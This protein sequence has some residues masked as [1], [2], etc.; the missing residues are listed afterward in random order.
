MIVIAILGLLFPG[1]LLGRALRSPVPWAI[2]FPLSAL[3]LAEIVIAY[4]LLGI[5]IRFGYVLGADLVVTGICLGVWLW[6]KPPAASNS[7]SADQA[8]PSR[9]FVILSAVLVGVVLLGILVR[10]MMFPLSGP[11]VIFRWD[12]LPRLMLQ[13]QSLSYYPPISA[14]DF[15][16]Y[17]Y[18]DGFPP[19]VATVYWWLYAAWGNAAPR[20]TSLA[21]FLQ[22]ATCFALVFYAARTLFGTPGGVLSL[23]VLASSAIFLRGVAIG[24]ENGYTAISYA[25]QLLFAFAAT[26]K[27]TANLV[28]IAGLFAGLGALTREYGPLLSLCGLAVLACRRETLRLAPLFCVVAIACGSPWFIRN[29]VLCRNPLYSMDAGLGFPVNPVLSGFMTEYRKVLGVGNYTLTGWLLVAKALLMGAPL[30]LLV[31]VPGIVAARKYGIALGISTLVAFL[32]WLAAVPKIA[33]GINHTWRVL[34]P[35]CVAFSISAGAFGYVLLRTAKR[36]NALVHVSLVLAIVICGGYAALRCWAE[37]F[38]LSEF[39]DAVVSTRKEPLDSLD[40]VLTLATKLEE[41]NLPSVGVLME[42]CNLAVALQYRTRFQPVME[43]SPEVAFLF[44]PGIESIKAEQMLVEK[45]IRLIVLS[46]TSLNNGYL[47]RVPFFSEGIRDWSFSLA[48]PHVFLV[49]ALP[50]ESQPGDVKLPKP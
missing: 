2:A 11:D 13:Y 6:R 23:I 49:V 25:G 16:K 30:A 7:G 34:T 45:N 37:P 42:D 10:T 48:V 26:R 19:L 32:L 22:A 5:P 46:W 14:E 24:Q 31:G 43:W 47:L 8:S 28:V 15:R 20:I 29:W 50:Q 3:L 41:S 27:P 12:A 18:P 4:T 21:I 44:K 17:T 1:Y 33:G 39:R 36:Q 9:I 38:E 35:A 40:F